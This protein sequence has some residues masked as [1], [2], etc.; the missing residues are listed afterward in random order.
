MHVC[1]FYDQNYQSKKHL[2]YHTEWQSHASTLGSYFTFNTI[3]ELCV[4]FFDSRNTKYFIA[5]MLI[6][7]ILQIN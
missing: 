7:S 4:L 6:L 2:V 5:L 3:N 1:P